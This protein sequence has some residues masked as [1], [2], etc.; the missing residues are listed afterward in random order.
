MGQCPLP[1]SLRAC[2]RHALGADAD[3]RVV[4]GDPGS[5]GALSPR[6]PVATVVAYPPLVCPGQRCACCA[7]GSERDACLLHKYSPNSPC[8]AEVVQPDSIAT[9]APTAGTAVWAPAPWTGPLAMAWYAWLCTAALVYALELAV[10]RPYC[11][12]PIP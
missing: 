6:A 9:H 12:A 2:P 10:A 8:P 4:P 7:S 1:V 3:A 5:G 11:K